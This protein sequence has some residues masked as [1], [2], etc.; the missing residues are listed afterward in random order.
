MG[1]LRGRYVVGHGGGGLAGGGDE[2]VGPGEH[3]GNRAGMLDEG[4]EVFFD[5]MVSAKI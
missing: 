4:S 3:G 2:V 1:L 5:V